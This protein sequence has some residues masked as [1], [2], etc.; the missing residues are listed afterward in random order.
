MF[1]KITLCGFSGEEGR[2][3]LLL[4]PYCLSGAGRPCIAGFINTCTVVS[5]IRLKTECIL[6]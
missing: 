1:S 3:S 4:L 5:N 6:Q 2:I